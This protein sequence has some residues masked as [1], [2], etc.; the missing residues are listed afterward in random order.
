LTFHL[1]GFRPLRLRCLFHPLRQRRYSIGVLCHA[2]A[3]RQHR[4]ERGNH[5][6][7][8]RRPQPEQAQ[9]EACSLQ[10]QQGWDRLLSYGLQQ[11]RQQMVFLLMAP[12]VEPYRV[13]A[14]LSQVRFN[15]AH[16]RTLALAPLAQYR[17][18]QRRLGVEVAK[19]L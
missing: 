3:K 6:A 9:P 14:V 7:V 4:K 19:K 17:N 2:E 1:F 18:R 11:I 10:A 8:S 15:Q 5:P 12:R 13:G 16:Q